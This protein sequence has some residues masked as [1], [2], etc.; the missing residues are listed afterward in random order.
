MVDEFAGRGHTVLG[1]GRS[2]R[3]T[4][5]LRRAYRKPH[6]FAVVDV[7]S[8]RA[9][10]LWAGRLLAEHGAPDLILN[11]AGVINEN[12][13]LWTISATE[14]SLVLDV[15]VKGSANVIRHFLP[16]MLARK[17]GVLV[18]F[19]SG[20]GRSTDG[21]VAPY[22]ASKW[23]IEGLTLALAQELPAGVAAVSLNPGIIDTEMLRSCFGPSAANYPSP[24]A[25]A[26]AAVP[27][28][29]KLG[30][31]ENGKQLTAP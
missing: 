29:L 20:W 30:P 27:F 18:N 2:K 6:D 31:K 12:A 26:K 24:T 14:F 5:T 10:K 3:E 21:E 13:P 15:N 9:V 28:L 7:A 17:K 23:A 11:N 4:E 19:S 1:C 22:C 16:A 8:D 25:W